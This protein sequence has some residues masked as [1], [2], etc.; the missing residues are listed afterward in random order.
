[1]IDFT[2]V[3]KDSIDPK[4]QN[5]GA[6]IRD[7]YKGMY[8]PIWLFW[9]YAQHAKSSDKVQIQPLDII[10]LFLPHYMNMY[11][12]NLLFVK[13]SLTS[14]TIWFRFFFQ[15]MYALL[16]LEKNNF[17]TAFKCQYFFSKHRFRLKLV[18]GKIQNNN[19]KY[20]HKKGTYYYKKHNEHFCAFM[21]T[22]YTTTY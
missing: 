11:T 12:Y 7:F 20:L 6:A 1:M 13:L 15:N 10:F 16:V 19:K 17:G 4:W 3:C 8:V 5:A 9:K 22:W 14:Y 18:W 2:I 21:Y